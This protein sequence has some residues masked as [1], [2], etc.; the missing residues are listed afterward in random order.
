M[1]L[2]F[3]K[4]NFIFSVLDSK[5]EGRIRKLSLRTPQLVFLPLHFLFHLLK[6]DRDLNSAKVRELVSVLEQ[7]LVKALMLEQEL[8]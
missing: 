7:L 5:I 8:F 3:V 2:Q 1:Q 4:I 6:P